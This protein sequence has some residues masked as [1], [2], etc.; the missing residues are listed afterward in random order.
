MVVL[1]MIIA[2][3]LIGMVRGAFLPPIV[4]M[5]IYLFFTIR[6]LVKYRGNNLFCFETLFFLICFVITFFTDVFLSL[7]D[8]V[9]A[10]LTH[11]TFS[12]GVHLKSITVQVLAVLLYILG[13]TLSER[14][15]VKQQIS[16]SSYRVFHRPFD[17]S[18]AATITSILTFIYIIFLF[19]LGDMSSWFKYGDS[20]D[21]YSNTS[22]ANLTV[23]C[24]ISTVL[25]F[26]RLS[27]RGV[28]SFKS[29]VVSVNKAYLLAVVFTGGIML[30]SG[31]RNE[32]LLVLLP[33]LF[34]YSIFVKKITN[35]NFIVLVIVG[36]FV[37]VF[38]GLTR[39]IGVSSSSIESVSLD[40]YSFFQDFGPASICSDYLI[41]YT[42]RSGPIWFGNAF[43]F[44]VSSIPFLG[45]VISSVLGINYVTRSTMITTEGMQLS[46]NME[47]G[48]GTNLVGD[49]YYTGGFLFVLVFFFF[50]G[51]IMS[52]SYKML[53][54][55]K[56]YNI[57]LLLNYVFCT[58]NAIY[59]ARAEWTMPLWYVGFSYFILCIVWLFAHKG[60]KFN[61][62]T[63]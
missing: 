32:A 10:V 16:F 52:K 29:A 20:S 45:G 34:S 33:I 8:S 18:T 11:T 6:F 43:L 15:H 4:L 12:D 28:R 19:L 7:F 2:V 54:I 63:N 46:N 22:V 44:L 49:V 13:G 36:V 27:S 9:S 24:L 47:S 21:S 17:F 37:M 55:E 51:F 35:A 25:E 56:N 14:K 62:E 58:S 31:N 38:I 42:D 26:T 3:L 41:E 48:L 40:L 30:L 59:Y 5:V 50:L 23:L 39:D 53:F 57:W 1:L 60:N 61:R